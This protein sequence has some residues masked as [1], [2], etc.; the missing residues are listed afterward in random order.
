[1]LDSPTNI[2]D[3][4]CDDN[5]DVSSLQCGSI[6]PNTSYDPSRDPRN[7]TFIPPDNIVITGKA[8][9]PKWLRIDH[10][11]SPSRSASHVIDEA[12]YS[13]E[14]D[15]RRQVSWGSMPSTT[16]EPIMMRPCHSST[17]LHDFEPQRSSNECS[18]DFL[19]GAKS[20][21]S[22]LRTSPTLSGDEDEA[23]VML[24]VAPVQL[25]LRLSIFQRRKRRIAL[26]PP[27]GCL[28]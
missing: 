23:S 13:H 20:T 2:S 18:P 14:V 19:R 11:E 22:T 24:E 17:P 4:E 5:S 3:F 16:Q 9:V 21:T 1:M 15:L 12:R 10:C 26:R 25:V 27:R 8:D 28:T 7:F 6:P